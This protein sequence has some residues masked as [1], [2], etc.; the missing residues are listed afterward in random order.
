MKTYLTINE[1]IVNGSGDLILKK[2]LNFIATSNY[3]V[4]TIE[5]LKHE[6]FEIVSHH[7]IETLKNLENLYFFRKNQKLE[8]QKAIELYY[9]QFEDILK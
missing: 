4:V 3:N 6:G 2:G 7:E 8:K 1:A 9:Q 5:T